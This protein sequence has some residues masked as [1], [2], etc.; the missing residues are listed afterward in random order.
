MR[1]YTIGLSFYN[2]SILEA[3]WGWDALVSDTYLA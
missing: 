3:F 2:V 1:V